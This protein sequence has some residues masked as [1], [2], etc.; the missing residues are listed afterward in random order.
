[1]SHHAKKFDVESD[2]PDLSGKVILVTGG[3]TG[4]GKATCLALAK[5][6]PSVLYIAARNLKASEST[7]AELEKSAPNTTA[8]FVPCDLASLASVQKAAQEVLL[9][10][11]R[12]DLLFCNAGILGAPPSLTK[13]GYEIHFGVNHLGHAL[14]IKLLMPVLLRTAELPSDVRVVV[15]SS[16]GYRFHASDGVVF[17]DLRTTQENLT[18]M[19]K[20]GAWLRYFQS[21]LANIL[22]T[23]E[24]AKRYPTIKFV[25]VHP[26]IVDTPLTPNWIKR[27]AIMRQLMAGGDLRTPDQGS[28]NQLWAATSG[29]VLSGGYYEPVG[30]VGKRTKKSKDQKLQEELWEWTDAQL[31]EWNI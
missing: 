21:K 23:V 7:I 11:P 10:T 8:I 2:I 6:N 30:L 25:A 28:W 15:T 22:Y 14:L 3:N 4:I 29:E 26:G 13:D 17:K 31:K 5:H 9:T 19:G 20:F 18:F 24:L 27:T 12:L 1:M 16:D